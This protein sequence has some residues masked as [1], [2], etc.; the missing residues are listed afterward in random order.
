MATHCSALAGESHG[1]RS[2]EGYSPWGHRGSDMTLY[3]LPLELSIFL[4]RTYFFSPNMI[5]MH[6]VYEDISFI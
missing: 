3:S 1:P 5:I 4:Q 6:F 2:L